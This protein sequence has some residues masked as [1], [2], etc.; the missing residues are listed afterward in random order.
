[1]CD[2]SQS[3]LTEQITLAKAELTQHRTIKTITRELIRVRDQTYLIDEEDE[4]NPRRFEIYLYQK[5]V[6]MLEQGRIF[7][8]ESEQNKRLED[9]LLSMDIWSREKQALIE[10][11]GLERLHQP[12]TQTLKELEG[13]LNNLLTRVTA[14][15]NADANDFVKCQPRTN[16]LTWSLANRR[17]KSSIDN[18]VYSQLRHMGIIEI[19]DYVNRKTGYLD[20][21]EGLSS[22]K[23]NTEAR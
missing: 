20:A 1:M 23:R 17:W 10:K 4:V 3:L 14:N 22:Q 2:V 13:N 11:T 6:R 5:V 21:F 7:V 18:P 8:S 16:R 19:M 12:I 15:I 9:D